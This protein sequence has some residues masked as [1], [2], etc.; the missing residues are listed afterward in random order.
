MEEDQHRLHD[1][2]LLASPKEIP[3][4]ESPRGM[5]NRIQLINAQQ[6]MEI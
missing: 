4:E 3:K 5:V 2:F 1:D 6:H